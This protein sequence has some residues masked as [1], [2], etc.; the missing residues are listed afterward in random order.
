MIQMVNWLL[1]RRCNLK[2]DYCGIV[3]DYKNKPPEYPDM[4]YY[5]DNEMSTEFIIESLHR[6]QLHNPLGF[7]IFYGGEPFLRNDLS[8]IIKYCNKKGIYYTVISNNSP[9]IENRIKKVFDEVGI[10]EGFSAS[11]DPI[12]DEEA[13][14]DE[15]KKSFYGM[16]KLKNVTRD[17]VKDPVAEITVQNHNIHNLYKLVKE[18]SD[19]NIYSSITFIDIAKN[20]YYDFSNVSDPKDL[21]KKSPE[22]VQQFNQIYNDKLLVHMGDTLL[23]RTLDSLPS[24]M[25]CEL[26]KGIHNLCIDA[27]KAKV[28]GSNSP[29]I[30]RL[31]V[32]LI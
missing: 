8:D 23:Q 30:F 24:N 29:V 10:I 32:D 12:Y 25:D 9:G 7:H 6:I 2:C 14:K 18:L 17:V 5:N 26:E 31:R 1:T 28:K 13:N 16:T 15:I 11:V 4:K 19:N 3:R 27:E 20:P 21:V 22:L